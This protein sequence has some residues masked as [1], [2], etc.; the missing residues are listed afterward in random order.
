M[1]PDQKFIE[2]FSQAE[3]LCNAGKLSESLEI[4]QTLLSEQ[5]DHVSVLNNMGLVNEKRLKF[6]E[7]ID[8]Y[9]RCNALMPNQPVLVNNLANAYTR[10]DRWSEALPLLQKIINVDFD[11]EKNSEKYALCLLNLKSKEETR[12]FVAS[13]IRKY[14]KNKLLNRVLGKTLL[15]LN[16]HQDGLKYLQRGAGLIEFTANGVEYLN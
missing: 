14:P 1:N 6:E 5:P 2:R 15:H 12:E 3:K 9:R 7:A 10:L 8:F 11:N 16:S 13:A 4:Y